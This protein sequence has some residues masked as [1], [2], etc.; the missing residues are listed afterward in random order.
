MSNHKIKIL[1]FKKELKIINSEQS[2][3][4]IEQD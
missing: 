4:F 1:E 2:L 3:D